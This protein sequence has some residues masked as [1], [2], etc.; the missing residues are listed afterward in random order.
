MIDMHNSFKMI[1][2]LLGSCSNQHTNSGAR[3]KD[4]II[5][6][7]DTAFVETITTTEKS[8]EEAQNSLRKVFLNSKPSESLK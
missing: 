7:V 5:M 1:A 8:F 4:T 6:T 2:L 3:E